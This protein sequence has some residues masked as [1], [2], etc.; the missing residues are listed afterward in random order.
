M[1]EAMA[2]SSRLSTRRYGPGSFRSGRPGRAPTR[3]HARRCYA[4]RARNAGRVAV[5]ERYGAVLEFL[6]DDAVAGEAQP[7]AVEPQRCLETL[8]PR[9]MTVMRD[10]M[11]GSVTG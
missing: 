7:L 11:S 6:R 1:D 10:R 4:A 8:N 5:D 2:A 3:C 9:M